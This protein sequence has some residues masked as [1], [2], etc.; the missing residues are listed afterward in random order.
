MFSIVLVLVFFIYTGLFDNSLDINTKLCLDYKMRPIEGEIVNI[1]YNKENKNTFH[2]EILIQDNI[3]IDVSNF[4]IDNPGHSFEVGD[5]IFKQSNTLT[6]EHFRDGNRVNIL[7]RENFDCD[8]WD[9]F[10]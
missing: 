3:V 6:I 5:S 4:Y 2:A 8:F 7:K 1:Y 10:K 9:K